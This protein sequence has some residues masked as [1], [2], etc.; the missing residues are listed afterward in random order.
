MSYAETIRKNLKRVEELVDR[1]VQFGPGGVPLFNWLEIS[2]IDVCNRACSFCPRSNPEAAPNQ[3]LIMPPALFGK[4][5]DEL[6]ALDYKGTVMLAGYGE[7]MLSPEIYA[8]IGRFSAVCNTEI[9]TNGDVLKPR[10]IERMAKAGINKIIVSL[11]DGPEQVDRF[12]AMFAEVGVGEELYILR[13][14]WYA[15]TDDF[16]VKLTNRAG[17][18]SVGAQ[19]PVDPNHKCY[20]THYSMN[21]DWNGDVYLCTQD[22]QRRVKSGNVMLSSLLDVWTSKGLRRFRTHLGR[23][24]RTLLPCSKCNADG[25]LHGWNH[26]AA[27][28]R[29]YASSS[30]G[31]EPESDPDAV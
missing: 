18:V 28:D 16:G 20:Y 8:M 21:I 11:Y 3:N 5:A 1:E 23:G 2:P 24:E 12:K 25:T 14:R 4:M 7:P 13:D 22:W 31:S 27:W 9:T 19:R 29:Y 10:T 30:H 15:A 6:A 26:A 17:M